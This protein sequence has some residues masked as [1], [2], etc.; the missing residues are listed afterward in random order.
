MVKSISEFLNTLA[1]KCEAV[2]LY[3]KKNKAWSV[4]N[5][6][7][8]RTP[9]TETKGELQLSS[10][11]EQEKPQMITHNKGKSQYPSQIKH[12]LKI[13]GPGHKKVKTRQEV[14]SVMGSSQ[15]V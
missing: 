4:N 15:P 5:K 3:G 14:I 1:P 6:E 9:S 11:P 2:P 12:R 13:N 8:V 7:D 10:I